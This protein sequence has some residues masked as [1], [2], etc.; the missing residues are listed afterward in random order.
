MAKG[1][2]WVGVLVPAG[3][4]KEIVKL[5]HHELTDAMAPNRLISIGFKL[6]AGIPEEFAARIAAKI[7]LW[8][9]VIRASE[10]KPQ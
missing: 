9:N 2:S 10:L 8:D 3:T 5:L 1:D 7:R 6:V 4:P